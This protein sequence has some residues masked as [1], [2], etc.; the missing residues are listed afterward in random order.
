VNPR[1][2]RRIS[3]HNRHAV[4]AALLSLAGAWL[5]WT[6]AY[7]LFVLVI[8]G[9]LTVGHGQ[10]VLLGERLMSLPAWIHPSAM[11]AALVL[12]VWAA[13]DER[14]HR[15]HPASDRPIIGWH[16]LGDVLLLPARLTFGVG[17]Q[18]A[19]VIRLDHSERVEALDLLHHIY[20]EKRCPLHSLGAWF[21]NPGRL[22][23]LLLALQMAGWTDLLRT[24]EGWIY[25]VRSTEADEV[26]AIFGDGEENSLPAGEE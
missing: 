25:I 5:G 22:R 15:F 3:S 16:L 18:L 7:G 20:T 19:A 14:L 21:P 24:E 4:L 23:K 1:F 12:L 10:E 26:A 11:A 17:H 2:Q 8:L 9:G 6:V 13:V